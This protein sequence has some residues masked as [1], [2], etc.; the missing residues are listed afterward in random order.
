VRL[1]LIVHLN[2]RTLPDQ[3]ADLFDKAINAL[4]QVDYGHDETDKRELSL[5]WTLY[6]D[7]AQHLAFHMHQQGADQGREIE[8]PA[9]RAILRGEAEFL[10]R[11]DD[12]LRQAQQRGSVLEERDGAYRFL[13]LALQEFLV[14]RY[15]SE[16]TGRES[17]ERMLEVLA[18]R[19]ADPWWREPILLLGGYQATHAARSAREL[20]RA[21]ADAA[22]DA[23]ARFAAAELAATAALEWRESGEPLRADC[24]RRIVTRLDDADALAGD[25]LAQLGDPRFDPQRFFLPADER[26]GFVRIAADP[27]FVIGTRGVDRE[28]VTRIAGGGVYDDELNELPTPTREFHIARYP[29]TVAQFRAFVAAT[30]LAIGDADALADPD[31]RPVR[32]V[33]WHEALAWC[34]WLNEM[35]AT[36]PALAGSRVAA[37]VREHGWRVALPSELDWEK[38]ARGG[39]RGAVFPWGDE[40]D[41]G[42]GRRANHA[43][44]GIGDPSVVGCFAANGHGLHDM[45]GNVWEWTRS[46][47]GS[48]SGKPDFAYPYLIDDPR[49]ED[50]RADDEVP[51]VVRGGSWLS[52][53]GLARCGVR[54]WY[55]PGD[56]LG[57]VG[58][59][60]LLRSSPVLPL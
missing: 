6:R 55:L 9:L 41:D 29:V 51:R 33:S 21:R 56:R 15:L 28:R 10:P 47:W 19:L 18:A 35:L 5:D 13:H 54:F 42:D 52:P 16:V 39:L 24:A 38:A 12:F 57:D 2:N 37:L 45:A 25:R 58:F 4:L 60:V 31:S 34:D 59:R 43:G 46:L 40:A 36:S 44:S 22:G 14:G 49:R 30:G 23:D 11:I 7:M 20:L 26:L 3:R 27:D 8:E 17:R 50:L 48:D 32:R 1:L 53:R